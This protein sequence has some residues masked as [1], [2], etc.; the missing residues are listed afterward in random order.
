MSDSEILEPTSVEAID[1]EASVL[2]KRGIGLLSEAGPGAAVEALACFDG[3]LALRRR[4]PIDQLPI[5]RY[6]LAACW[7][8]RA[9]ALMSMGDTALAIE[10]HDEAILLLTDLPLFDDLRFPRRLAIAHQNRG[11]ALQVRGD[12]FADALTAFAQAIAVLEGKAA[13]QMPDR[14]YLLAAV[15]TNVAH[16]WISVKGTPE[17]RSMAR[18]AARQAIALTVASEAHE[19]DY[20]EV[21]LKARHV[22]CQAIAGHLSDPTSGDV[23]RNDIDEATDAVDDGLTVARGW[24]QKGVTWFRGMAC[25]LF[26][27]GARVYAAYQPQ[28]LTEFVLDNTDPDNSSTGYV[29]SE[30]MRAAAEEALGLAPQGAR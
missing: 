23:T 12:A 14:L 1:A 30:E 8:N 4:L 26:R 10:A 16:A 29:D 6:G 28:F 9:E 21:A 19:A 17:S 7:L 22:L 15:W 27:F 24:E 25:D 3:A 2:M 13:A 18:S 20:A 11:L 5:L